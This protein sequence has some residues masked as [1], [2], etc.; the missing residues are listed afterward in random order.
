MIHVIATIEVEPG[1]RAELV[2]ILKANVPN[3]LSEDGC[4]AYAPAIDIDAGLDAQPSLRE[5]MVVVIEQWA[6]IEHLHAHLNAPHMA[7]YRERVKH[8]VK[9]SK[10][11][12]LKPV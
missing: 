4:L 3:V 6:S 12:V 8:I 7:A 1:K 5:N 11:R 2:E 9:N 10:L